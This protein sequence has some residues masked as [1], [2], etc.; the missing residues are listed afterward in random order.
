MPL[1]KAWY[2]HLGIA[3]LL[4]MFAFLAVAVD[5]VVARTWAA[6]N[7]VTLALVWALLQRISGP[8]SRAGELGGSLPVSIIAST[9]FA[10]LALAILVAITV[11]I[12]LT[13]W[14]V[15]QNPDPSPRAERS[16]P[17]LPLAL[18]A[19]TPTY[20]RLLVGRFRRWRID[21]DSDGMRYRG[22]KHDTTV[23]WRDVTHVGTNERGTVL[24]VR[25]GDDLD[26]PLWA[27][28]HCPVEVRELVEHTWRAHRA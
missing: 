12:V 14:E 11:T 23:P 2:L 22:G 20:A 18:V 7:V 19:M 8:A 27:F 15:W 24:K 28:D 26:V 9:R 6:A 3:V 25:A 5:E 10:R 13:M 17:L 16:W 1:R 4:L 21:I